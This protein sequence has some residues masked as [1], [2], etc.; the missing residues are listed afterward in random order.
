MLW[1]IYV[2]KIQYVIAEIL[3][4]P[5]IWAVVLLIFRKW[6]RFLHRAC[7]ALAVCSAV[8]ILYATLANRGGSNEVSLM[9]FASFVEA[10]KQREIYRSMLMN[11]LLFEPLGLCLPLALP[12]RIPHKI[13]TTILC[14]FMLSV[15]I[16][17]SQ[18]F[19]HLGLCET[20]DVIMNTL[21]AALGCCS[22]WMVKR[23][24]KTE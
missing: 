20:D 8:G 1:Y 16:E 11:M 19:F 2:Q 3:L 13:R 12:E 23:H 14:A 21:G 6:P 24:L 18:F 17:A 5:V 9:P 22:Y 7:I 4:L 15:F 10:Q